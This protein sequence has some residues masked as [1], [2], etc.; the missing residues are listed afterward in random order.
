MRKLKRLNDQHKHFVASI[1]VGDDP[2]DAYVAAGWSRS[3]DD[4]AYKL[5]ADPLIRDAINA[6]KRK[7]QIRADVTADYVLTGLK[8][9]CEQALGRIPTKKTVLKD[10]ELVSV[11]VCEANLA[12]ANKGLENLG[13]HLKLFTDQVEVSTHE[14][15]LKQL[16]ERVRAA[17]QALPEYDFSD[18][19]H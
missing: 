8:E 15:A 1:V 12:A 2:R 3:N 4:R 19:R 9:V 13:R 14:E 18:T 6:A 5:M 11:E 10:G 7:S 17:E 16:A